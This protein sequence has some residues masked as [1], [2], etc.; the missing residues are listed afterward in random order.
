V[1]LHTG[2]TFWIDQKGVNNFFESEEF[3]EQVTK[4]M[5]ER[6]YEEIMASG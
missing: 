6:V 5:I 2:I 3:K 4:F 1:K